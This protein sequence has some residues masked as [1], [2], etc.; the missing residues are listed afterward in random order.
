MVEECAVKSQLTSGKP[1]KNSQGK[2]CSEMICHFSSLC[3]HPGS[4]WKPIIQLQA[5]A[6]LS[7]QDLMASE[8]FLY[9]V[10]K[11]SECQN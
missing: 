3:L 4:P 8:N 1:V 5:R 6:L 7:F 10:K 9:T 2:K 11:I